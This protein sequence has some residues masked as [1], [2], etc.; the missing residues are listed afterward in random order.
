MS[1]DTIQPKDVPRGKVMFVKDEDLS[2]MTDDIHRA[3]THYRHLD[4]L[5]KPDFS[6][7]CTQPDHAGAQSRTYYPPV[8]R[9]PRDLSLTT[10]DIEGAQ[11]RGPKRRGN[12]HTDPLCPR[13]E[14]PSSYVRPVTPPRYNGRETNDI[15]DIEFSKPKVLAPERNYVR[16]PNESRDIEFNEPSYQERV[17]RPW[18]PRDDRQHQVRDITGSYQAPIRMT[19]PLDPVY[20][21]STTKATSVRARYTEESGRPETPEDSRFEGAVPGSKPRRRQWDNGQPQYALQTEDIAGARSQRWVGEVPVNIYDPPEVRPMI[22]FHDP[23]DVPGAQVGTLKKG[24]VTKRQLNP[25]MPHYPMLDGDQRP[26]PVPVIP[27]ERAHNHHPSLQRMNRAASAA[28]LRSGAGTPQSAGGGRGLPRVASE[29]SLQPGRQTPNGSRLGDAAYAS[30]QSG[31]F[32]QGPGTYGL[33]S[34][35]CSPAM[36]YRSQSSSAMA[37]RRM[38][39]PAWN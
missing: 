16:D 26:P 34:G 15:S 31:A 23:C 20:K 14:L 29:G 7:G 21:V 28:D 25:L 17:K 1:L 9:R 8:D 11:F 5:Q 33:G 37:T 18:K 19:N 22:D 10:A 12:R 4:Y 2:L 24:I 6:V 3:K 38:D 27:G 30:G 36:S 35:Q 13:Y 32:C 39:P